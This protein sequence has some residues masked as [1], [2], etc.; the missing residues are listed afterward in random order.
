MVEEGTGEAG[1]VEQ[2][3]TREERVWHV[4]EGCR[5]RRSGGQFEHR[6]CTRRGGVSL[7]E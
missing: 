5:E 6:G 4:E 3:A 7:M 2:G 1:S